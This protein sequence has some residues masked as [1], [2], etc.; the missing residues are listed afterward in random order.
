MTEDA[1][2]RVLQEWGR[3][4][5]YRTWIELL[6]QPCNQPLYDVFGMNGFMGEMILGLWNGALLAA[7][8][9]TT[10][11]PRADTSLQLLVDELEG[12]ERGTAMNALETAR[13]AVNETGAKK[14]RDKYVAH[15]DRDRAT[16]CSPVHI[17]NLTEISAKT[18]GVL[19]CIQ[20]FQNADL[21]PRLAG[22][23]LPVTSMLVRLDLF[24]RLGS[25][26]AAHVTNEDGRY[27]RSAAQELRKTLDVGS[28]DDHWPFFDIQMECFETAELEGWRAAYE[29]ACNGV[30][31]ALEN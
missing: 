23:D 1:Y 9:L 16:E 3:F 13:A 24:A 5:R 10:N 28:D 21:A 15:R 19:R 4:E 27:D 26:V 6:R 18:H 30:T 31:D 2:S 12:D 8:N 29:A 25:G 14:W 17:E 11:D 7:V 20:R 22:A